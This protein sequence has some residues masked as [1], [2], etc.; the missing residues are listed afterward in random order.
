MSRARRLGRRQAGELVFRRQPR[1]GQGAAGQGGQRLGGEIGGGDEGHPL[2]DK[3]A[4]AQIGAFAAFDIFQ[5]AQPVGDAGGDIF[6]QQGVG[7]VG[8]G[9][10]GGIE[11]GC[12]NGLGIAVVMT[13][14][15]REKPAPSSSALAEAVEPSLDQA[16]IRADWRRCLSACS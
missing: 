14:G 3:D 6:H 11:Q 1:H 9:L 4:Q 5:F 10:F 16:V 8:A 13:F 12:E 15:C 2:A 7:G